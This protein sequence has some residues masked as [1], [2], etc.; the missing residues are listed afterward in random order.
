MAHLYLARGARPVTEARADDLEEQQ[1]LRLSRTEI[2]A[3]LMTNEFK[4]LPWASAVALALLWTS[5]APY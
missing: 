4:V 5:P 1:L 2:E 3:A